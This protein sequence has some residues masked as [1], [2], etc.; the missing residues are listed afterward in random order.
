M[1]VVADSS[2]LIV[3]VEIGHIDVLPQLFGQVIVPPEVSAELCGPRRPQPVREFF[4]HRPTWLEER[5]PTAIEPIP[6]LHSGEVAAISL[7]K[8]L[9][10]DLLLIDAARPPPSG[11]SR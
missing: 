1:L 3:L 6:A 11:V 9:E 8:E 5:A 4:Q 7:A 2:P 10:A